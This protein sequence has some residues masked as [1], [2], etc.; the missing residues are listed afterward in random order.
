SVVALTFCRK[1][2][3]DCLRGA[4]KFRQRMEVVIRRVEA[5]DFE[6]RAG[7]RQLRERLFEPRD[8]GRLFGGMNEALIPEPCRREM[9]GHDGPPSG[10][11]Y[12]GEVRPR[13]SPRHGV[14][15]CCEGANGP[16]AGGPGVPGSP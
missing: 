11:L 9:C 5:M 2:R 10:G 13:V 14:Y 4:A 15:E 7:R 16:R 1:R 3:A 6:L 8:V 12:S